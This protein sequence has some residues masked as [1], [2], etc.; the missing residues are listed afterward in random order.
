[1]ADSY[2]A[3]SA[4][5]PSSTAEMAAFNKTAKYAGL[6]ADYHLQPITMESLDR[7]N[8]LAVYFLV[9]LGKKI[10]QQTGDERETA[11]LFQR[12]SVLVQCFTIVCDF[13]TL[14][15]MMTARIKCH[16]LH[17]QILKFF[18]NPSGSLIPRVFKKNNNN[19]N[20]IS[21]FCNVITLMNSLNI[22]VMQI[23]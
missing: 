15:L 17:F 1:M 18:P 21:H 2:I 4:W 8:E 14:L 7:A 5:E 11:F 19:N 20:N 10:A 9:A 23:F 6:T 13:T 16:F 22:K 12:L 3:S